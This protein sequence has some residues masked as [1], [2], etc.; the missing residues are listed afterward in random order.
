MIGFRK[1]VVPDGPTLMEQAKQIAHRLPID[2][3]K[4]P[5]DGFKMEGKSLSK[6]M[7]ISGELAAV[8]IDTLQSRK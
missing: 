3:F 4:P 7:G 5:M 1:N 2:G 6:S 8:S